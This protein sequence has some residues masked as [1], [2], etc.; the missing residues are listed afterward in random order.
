MMLIFSALFNLNHFS[1]W[2]PKKIYSPLKTSPNKASSNSNSRAIEISLEPYRQ[3]YH[4][5]PERARPAR[6]IASDNCLAKIGING[7]QNRWKRRRT[8]QQESIRS[9][10]SVYWPKKSH[11][12]ERNCLQHLWRALIDWL[13]SLCTRRNAEFAV[14]VTKKTVKA[15]E[16]IDLE[17]S[18]HRK[19]SRD[20]GEHRLFEWRQQKNH[21]GKRRPSTYHSHFRKG[22]DEWYHSWSWL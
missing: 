9:L 6:C 2:T 11:M 8:L 20:I 21:T 13:H 4:P 18:S 22:L 3:N 14:L 15:S 16:D 19:S 5:T 10:I 17:S 12:S 1:S 7:A